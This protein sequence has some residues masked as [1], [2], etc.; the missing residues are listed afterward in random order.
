MSCATGPVHVPDPSTATP[1]APAGTVARSLT[2]HPLP[3]SGRLLLSGVVLVV[4]AVV[5]DA[6]GLRGAA[7][8][9]LFLGAVLAGSLHSRPAFALLTAATTGSCASVAGAGR[10]CCCSRSPRC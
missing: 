9:V 4:L 6:A 10:S 5:C 1:T 3:R 2:P 7:A 8:T